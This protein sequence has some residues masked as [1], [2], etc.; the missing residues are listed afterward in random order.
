ML[1]ERVRQRRD[2]L[3]F[4]ADPGA[5]ARFAAAYREDI[6]ANRTAAE[7]A[8]F[9]AGGVAEQIDAA[10]RDG[11]VE[12]ALWRVFNVKLWARAHWGAGVPA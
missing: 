7:E 8:W 11:S 4:A 9:D 5:A 12:F 10:Q 1:P 3:G 6:V 2:K